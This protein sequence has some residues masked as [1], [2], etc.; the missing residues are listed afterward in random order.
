MSHDTPVAELTKTEARKELK[1]LADEIAR[2]DA[3][4]HG[5]DAPEISDA[6]YDALRQRNAAIEARFPDL[7]RADSPSEKIGAAPSTQF[8]AVRH[9]KPMLSLG[10]V[11]SETEA[12]EFRERVIRFLGLSDDE[13]LAITAEPKIDGLSASLRY[14][15]GALVLGATRGDGREGEDVTANLKTIN[16]IP[17]T[18]MGAP[19]VLEV[20]GE[21]FLSHADFGAMNAAREEAGEELYKN[22]RNAAAGSVRQKDAGVTASRPLAFFAY[23]WGELS[24]PLADTQSGAVARLKA[25]GFRTNPL[26]RRCVTLEEMLE[27]YAEIEGRRADLGYDIDGVVYKVDR[28]DWQERLGFVSRAPR[29]ATAHKFPAEQATTVLE[30]IDIQ[31]GRT[32][33]LTPVAKL[34]PVTVGGVVV[35]N[36]TL[37]NADEIERL[38]VREGDTVVVQ[39]AGDVIPQVVRVLIEK[40]PKGAKPFEFPMACPVCGSAV[41]QGGEEDDKDVVRRCT[42]GLVCSAQAVAR[43]KHFVSRRAMDIE[44][45][46]TKQIEAFF[47]DGLVKEPADIFTLEKRDSADG[48][49]KPL[50]A[51]EG[52]GKKSVD[53]LFAAIEARRTFP[54]N[55]LLFG[56]GV[57]H[58]GETTSELLARHYGSMEALRGAVESIIAG[59]EA[60]REDL[61]SIDGVGGTVVEA[62]TEFF[63]EAHN[64]EA[65]DRL[66]AEVSPELLEALPVADSPVAGKTVV[67]TGKLEKMTRDEAKARAAALGAKVAGSVSSKTDYL[68]AGAD[69][70][71]KLKKAT[72]LGVATLTEDE[73]L[74][75]AGN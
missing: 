25:L 57:R 45:L 56:L 34:S 75:M 41:A 8:S 19:D 31:V 46:G 68:V 36:A 29:W 15:E 70:G 20:R 48:N 53:N 28:L 37:H 1:A 10:N 65:L 38:D 54:L 58:V 12:R 2:H 40:R 67:F 5:E 50:R 23:A 42:G 33:A 32:G 64:L 51:R 16:D 62:L 49:L 39:R 13:E 26:M 55:R 21:V 6:D 66:M 7:K 72:E 24:E 47:T 73:W 3:L 74:E 14:E 59:D 44:G 63:A 71:S 17:H 22:P 52:F 27:T 9:A 35:S 69:A 4:Y 43:L 11:F 61:L 60:A 30:K 18:L